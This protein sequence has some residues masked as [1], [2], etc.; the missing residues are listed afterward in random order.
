MPSNY[1]RKGNPMSALLAPLRA[2]RADMLNT[3]T[4][5][6][7]LRL[8]TCS[9]ALGR[10]PCALFSDH[11]GI[12]GCTAQKAAQ[13]S[14]HLSSP[15]HDC[16]CGRGF[17]ARVKPPSAGCKSRPMQHCLR[18]NPH[19]SGHWGVHRS[20][21]GG[22]QRPTIREQD[23]FSPAVLCLLAASTGLQ[24]GVRNAATA[25]LEGC[26]NVP[27]GLPTLHIRHGFCVWVLWLRPLRLP[28]VPLPLLQLQPGLANRCFLLPARQ[29]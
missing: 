6:S 3:L 29:L 2:C 25:A 4:K 12:G 9:C 17:A 5:A 24:M 22:C 18:C 21:S 7:Y 14:R 1:P 13:S 8:S 15:C 27:G 16:T 26:C 28:A 19:G 23:T 10:A 20:H 11:A